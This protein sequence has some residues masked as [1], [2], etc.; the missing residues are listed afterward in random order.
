MEV[1]RDNLSSPNP[2]SGLRQ[3][4]LGVEECLGRPGQGLAEVRGAGDPQARPH[5]YLP[6]GVGEDVDD[7]LVRGG[8]HA[9][10]VDLD[11]PVSHADA[12]P[13]RYPASHEAA[14]LSGSEAASPLS[15]RELGGDVR[16]CLW[17]PRL[18]HSLP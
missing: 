5:S 10:P 1:L 3:T 8:D 11:D 13:L 2:K 18:L 16:L 12:S 15:G 6:H 9:L 14:D 4:V 7:L 17:S